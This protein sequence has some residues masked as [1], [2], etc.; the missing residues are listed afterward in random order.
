M[1]R[2]DPIIEKLFKDSGQELLIETGG[3][4]NMRTPAGML[5]VL[6]QNLTSQQILGAIA[7]LLPVEQRATFPPEG[8]TAFPYAAPAGQVQVTL[9]N[10]QGRVKVSLVPFSLIPPP[11]EE[12]KFELASPYEMLDMAAKAVD[13]VTVAEE[14]AIPVMPELEL[15][16]PAPAVDAAPAPS[17]PHMTPAPIPAVIVPPPPAPMPAPAV[18]APA[19]PAARPIAM[20][21]APFPAVSLPEAPVA[22]A[23]PGVAPVRAAPARPMTMPPV[24][25][26]APAPAPVPVAA[27]A[28]SAHAG[29][30][31]HPPV[32]APAA[33]T[34]AGPATHSPIPAPAAPVLAPVAAAAPAAPATPV[35]APVAAAVP[36]APVG[37]EALPPVPAATVPVA[38]PATSAEEV[39]DHRKEAE[40]QMVA[41]MK[42]MLARDASD[43][44]LTSET[45]PHMR[46]DGDMVAVEEYGVLAHEKLK[47]ML[48]SIAPDKNRKQWE[49]IR[50][51]DFAYDMAQAR[52]RIN[53]F[54]DRKGIGAVLRQIPSKI[55]TAEEIGLTRHVLDLCFLTK[56][57]V[58]VTGPTGSGKSTTLAALIDYINRFREDHIITIEDPI[59]FVHRNKSCLV[60][61]REVGVHT[62]SFK[63][64]LRAALREDPD[65]VL[66]G[67][68]RDL[69]TIATA[70]ETAETGH[71]VFG[72][73]H[74]NTAA[75]TVDRII[76]QFPADRQP[77]I[78]MML[79]E[80]LKGVIAQ[81]LCKRI[82]GGR[83]AAQEVL[84][85][86]GS[87]S[88]LIREGKTF[89]I[90]SVMQTSRGQGMVTL[91][92]SLL[93]LVKKK[94]IEP[95]E[96][97]SKSVARS[98]MR[99][100]LER[101]GFK[102]DSPAPG[103]PA[104][105]PAGAPAEA[106]SA[107]K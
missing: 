12:E 21:P 84:L 59:E 65:V 16:A 31:T 25:V 14:P 95:N 54:E 7:E 82:G 8:S 66:V 45:L 38:V 44:H 80:S 42:A 19:A 92:D 41:L 99:A 94:V 89:Q 58:L 26:A 71:L 35:S 53:I 56:G 22:P 91:N 34:Q 107:T 10:V 28:P 46:I 39:Q 81:V 52:F 4:V 72:T 102:V 90:P 15:D 11:V 5:P 68:M 32:P 98:E 79:S 9:E 18:V 70:I 1:A 51:T 48:F 29:P 17:A 36:A 87:V 83:V 86:T 64:A 61:Q 6:K 69:E 78:R 63:N 67:E 55:R 97:L 96:A 106:A 20:T 13:P 85:C 75:S 3:G 27:A 105:S 57:L 37:P 101:T 76:D 77:Q 23:A 43:L 74:T 88:N 60:N 62:Q 24:P 103:A 47:A 49:E 104:A 50:D 100:M 30:A 40:A 93:E 33:V 2:L 73:L